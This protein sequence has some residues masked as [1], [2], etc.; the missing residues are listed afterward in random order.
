[1]DKYALKLAAVLEELS[2]RSKLLFAYWI[3]KRLFHNYAYFN[4]QTFFGDIDTMLDAFNLIEKHLKH[5]YLDND[6][7]NVAIENVEKNTPDTNNFE[8]IIV[9]FALD[10]CNALTECLRYILDKDSQHVVDVGIFARDTI[11]MFIQEINDMDY[12][13][14]NFELSIQNDKHMRE[15]MASQDD[16]LKRLKNEEDILQD[17]VFDKIIDPSIVI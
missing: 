8:T 4:Q 10:A 6:E 14:P 2:P 3:S 11:D 7:I 17:I 9:S 13:D 5:G 12:T 16:V 1:M 15:E